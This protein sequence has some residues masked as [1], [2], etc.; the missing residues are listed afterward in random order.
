[1]VDC[2]ERPVITPEMKIDVLLEEYPEVEDTL[3]ELAPTLEKLKNPALR[4]TI[5]GLT[6]IRKAAEAGGVSMGEMIGK[7]RTAAGVEE[8]WNEGDQLMQ[9]GSER[10]DWL[11]E[12]NIVET[13]DARPMIEAGEHP[14]PQVMS[15][16][17]K[18]G[19]GKI[20]LL[21]APFT[22][23]PLIDKVRDAGNLA[24]SEQV[25]PQEFK[26]YFKRGD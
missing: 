7:L 5:A 10:P 21:K 2:P 8:A 11:I 19:E 4:E 17:Q 25:G 22:P 24:W 9:D 14:M 15:G 23:S 1:M 12:A 20:F 3:L 26:T 16:V 6:D 13:L 18:L